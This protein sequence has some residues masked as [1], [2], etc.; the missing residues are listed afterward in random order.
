MSY[1]KKVPI[2]QNRTPVQNCPPAYKA[3][4][5][6]ASDGN[7][8]SVITLTDNTTEIEVATVGGAGAVI[9]W[10][11]ATETASVS[12]QGSVISTGTGRNFDHV[13]PPNTVRRFVVPVE[14]GAV[15]S[16]VGINVKEGLY[17]RFAHIAT[18]APASSVLTAEY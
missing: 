1:P 14:T 8:S 12:P 4:A 18:V 3:Q 17:K 15:N 11:P 7:A 13:I 10:V 9:R 5:R 16:I 6:Y 2:D